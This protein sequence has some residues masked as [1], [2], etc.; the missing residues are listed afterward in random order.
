M[1]RKFFLYLFLALGTNS[2]IL[3]ALPLFRFQSIVIHHTASSVDTYASIKAFH[4][5]KFGWS[6]AGY[7]LILNNG[8]GS[9][10]AGFLEST[11]RY[12]FLS[13]SLATRNKKYNLSGIHICIVGNYSKTD[14]PQNMRVALAH[15]VT[16][17]QKKYN[18][19]S[20][21]IVF[22]RDVSSTECPGKRIT[23]P[24][25]HSWLKNLSDKVPERVKEQQLQ[26]IGNAS[27]LFYA[28][29]VLLAVNAIILGVWLFFRKK[30]TPPKNTY[31][32]F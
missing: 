14:M 31:R 13:Y 16:T 29:P 17:L 5:R 22:H 1:Y 24:R 21:N 3:W 28:L 32:C 7:H 18:I 11:H 9:V 8:K 12:R 20:K 26:V 27:F 30:K 25:L 6:D 2:L 19:S 4:K 23:K 10:P 15:A